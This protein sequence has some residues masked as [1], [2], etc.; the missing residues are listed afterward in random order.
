MQLRFIDLPQLA[1][2]IRDAEFASYI[3]GPGGER[4]HV[5]RYGGQD[6]VAV[7]HLGGSVTVVEADDDGQASIHAQAAETLGDLRGGH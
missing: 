2:T 5:I 3:D 7:H 4:V 6:I 1:D